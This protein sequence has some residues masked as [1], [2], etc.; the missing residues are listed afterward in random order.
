ML[1]GTLGEERMPL[2][3]KDRGSYSWNSSPSQSTFD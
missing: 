1:V 3:N 2:I